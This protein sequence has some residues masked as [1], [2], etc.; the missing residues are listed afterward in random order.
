MEL[1]SD[2][3]SQFVK[4]TKDDKKTKSESTVYGTTVEYDG[5]LYVKLDGSDLLTPVSKTANA[6]PDE[7]VTVMIKDHTATITGNITSPA[8]RTED[9]ETNASKISEFEIIV[10]HKVTVEE[11]EAANATIEHLKATIANIGSMEVLN[12]E[13]ENLQ[14]KFA[15]LEYVNAKDVEILN[16]EIENLQAK[17]GDFTDLSTEN[18]EA[19]NASIQELK[20]YTAD[21]T[22]V[23]ADVLSAVKADIKDLDAK[24]LSAEQADLIYANIDFANIG[25]AA[26]RHLFS[27]YGLIKDIIVSN[28]TITGELVGVTIKGD[29]IEGGTV[30]ADKLV[31]K[32]SDGLYY[33]LNVEAGVVESTEVTKEELQNGLHGT[34]IIAKSITAE[35][36]AVDDLVAFGATIGGFNIT[37]H[38]LYSGVKSS[39]DNTTRGVYL[40]RDGQMSVGDSNNFLR[41][42]KDENGNYKLEISASS[43]VFSAN[44]KNIEQIIEDGSD[45][46]IGARN[47]IRNS[48]T[49]I[50]ADYGFHSAIY[51]VNSYVMN[52]VVVLTAYSSSTST[53]KAEVID[54][55]LVVTEQYE[56]EPTVKSE[57]IN[58]ILSVK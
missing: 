54:D 8:A 5:R 34:A 27:D 55:V 21:F 10:A 4:A 51:T 45:L 15:S 52:D 17:F 23:S 32:G 3:I 31:V 41:Y 28:G 20:G 53:F 40:D 25:E 57:I 7:R 2:L 12:A 13:I 1:S 42:Y 46:E 56:T 43:L 29:L 30:K 11:L 48:T 39:A 24:K 50:F 33:K 35:K 19:L 58:D 49:L 18:L 26:I 6:N 36:I 9:V 22:Y 47:L 37:N 44:G 38:S 14:A 16:A